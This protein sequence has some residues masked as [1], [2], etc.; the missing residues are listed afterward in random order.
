[1]IL[2]GT[3]TLALA[4][5]AVV[6]GA[7]GAD[8][9]RLEALSVRFSRPVPVPSELTTA[10]WDGDDGQVHFETRDSSGRSVLSRGVVRT[11]NQEGVA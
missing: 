7:L 9:D 6:D 11:G 8:P 2:H 10:F 4:T 3:C 5:R 1:V